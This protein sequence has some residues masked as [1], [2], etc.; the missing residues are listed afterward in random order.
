MGRVTKLPAVDVEK[1]VAE[2]LARQS[3]REKAA[4]ARAGVGLTEHHHAV[5]RA[6]YG[7]NEDPQGDLA[8]HLLG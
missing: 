5:V 8:E 2:E 4:F 6:I 3:E 7:I 1:Q